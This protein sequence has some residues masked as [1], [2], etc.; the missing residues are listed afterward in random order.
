[1]TLASHAESCRPSSIKA[2][3]AWMLHAAHFS[4]YQSVWLKH[5][6]KGYQFWRHLVNNTDVIVA[7]GSTAALVAMALLAQAVQHVCCS[8]VGVELC[9]GLRQ[10]A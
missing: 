2:A 7:R 9:R 8:L 10:P 5:S 4:N 1:M 6:V 3:G